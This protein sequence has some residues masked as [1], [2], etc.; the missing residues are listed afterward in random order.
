MK[1]CCIRLGS[2][3]IYVINDN[4]S[5]DDIFKVVFIYAYRIY[6][7]N[8]SKCKVR[9]VIEFLAHKSISACGIR[10]RLVS[11]YGPNITNRKNV[12]KWIREFR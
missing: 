7:E 10:R 12:T 5:S 4:R 9:N 11:P 6:K 3:I 1:F 8:V 2:I